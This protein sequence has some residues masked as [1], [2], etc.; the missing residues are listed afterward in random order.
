MVDLTPKI[1]VGALNIS[2]LNASVKRPKLLGQ[3]NKNM[4]SNVYI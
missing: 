1:P 2:R 3:V 4:K